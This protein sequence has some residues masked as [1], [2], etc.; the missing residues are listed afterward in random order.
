M[1]H[2]VLIGDSIF[3]NG[4][5]V[6]VGPPVIEQVRKRLGNEYKATLL[7]NDGDVVEDVIANQL[8]HIPNDATHLV[9]SVGGNNALQ[10]AFILSERC[11]TVADALERLGTRADEFKASYT[12]MLA[13]I[14]EL[15]LPVCICTIYDSVP[16][17]PLA[18]K[19]GTALFNDVITR[20]A[21][22]NNLP[23]IDLRVICT[24]R[25]DYSAIS[26][27]EPS[28][29]GGAKIADAICRFVTCTATDD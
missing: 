5:Y 28:A 23:R 6:P 19:A 12:R 14:L 8:Q 24:Q 27:I 18:A 3:D 21:S 7:A 13:K 22:A 20:S 15:G 10:S 9:I 25:E 16:G 26:P 11:A 1:K 2:V 17:L 29:I 4:A